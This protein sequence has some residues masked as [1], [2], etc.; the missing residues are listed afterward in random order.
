MD[1]GDVVRRVR[2]CHSHFH[3]SVDSLSPPRLLLL[4]LAQNPGRWHPLTEMFVHFCP[5]LVVFSVLRHPTRDND[6]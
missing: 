6:C 2:F 4:E 1:V 3:R 5:F